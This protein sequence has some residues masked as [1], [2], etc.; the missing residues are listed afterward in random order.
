[1]RVVRVRHETEAAVRRQSGARNLEPGTTVIRLAVVGPIASGKSTVLRLLG[2]LGAETCSADELARDVTRPGEPALAQI[3]A[4]FGEAYR[5]ADGTLDRRPM[6]ELIF[7][8]ADARERLEAILHPAI[9]QRMDAWLTS[10]RERQSPPPVAAV[11]VLRLPV[12]LRARDLFDVVWL[13]RASA[14]ARLRRLV[15]RDAL[16]EADA[17]RRIEVQRSQHIEDCGPDLVVDTEGT[18]EQ[19]QAQIGRA[20]NAL[21][22]PQ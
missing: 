22:R 5:R 11:E 15:E 18:L 8:S 12:H 14:P 3:I 21:L 16:S 1:M 9:L 19:L 7:G 6:G 10:V 13:C 2:A 20:W 17:H 4:E